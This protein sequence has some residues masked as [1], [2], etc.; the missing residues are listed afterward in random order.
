LSMVYNVIFKFFTEE[1]DEKIMTRFNYLRDNQI[2]TKPKEFLRQLNDQNGRKARYQMK[3]KSTSN[4][5]G[6]YVGQDLPNRIAHNVTQ[7]L[8]LFL[9]GSSLVN[10]YKTKSQV[11]AAET[12]EGPV[13]KT[14]QKLC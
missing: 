14:K 13:Y 10:N 4:I 6:L 2:I 8:R 12:P 1:E 3:D 5:V 7:R 9:T 11:K